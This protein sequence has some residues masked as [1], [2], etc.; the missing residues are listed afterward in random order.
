MLETLQTKKYG[1][2]QA[3]TA[4]VEDIHNHV[5]VDLMHQTTNPPIIT[6]RNQPG[7]TRALTW[8]LGL[9]SSGHMLHGNSPIDHQNSS[10][11]INNSR[12]GLVLLRLRH[13]VPQFHI[14]NIQHFILPLIFLFFSPILSGFHH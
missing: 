4:V 7:L 11:N 3:T 10:N 13:Q 12:V 5:A 8:S 6:Q 1:P 9:L 2:P 14:N